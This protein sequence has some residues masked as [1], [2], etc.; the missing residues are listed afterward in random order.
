MKKL[1]RYLPILKVGCSRDDYPLYAQLVHLGKTI[2]TCNDETFISVDN[3][4]LDVKGNTNLFVL[5]SVI[6]S[7]PENYE[8]TQNEQFIEISANKFKTKLALLDID[9]PNFD[10]PSV[11]MVEIDESLLNKISTAYRFTGEDLLSYIY[12]DQF[13]IC[14]TSGH[15]T[16]T[17]S[18][19]LD[20]EEGLF[21]N[22]KILSVLEEGNS[23][24]KDENGNTILDF[25]DGF[26][27]FTVDLTDDYPI[28]KIR[29]FVAT[30]SKGLHELCNVIALQVAVE[31]IS[32]IFFGEKTHLIT[33]VNKNNE[34]RVVAE[35]AMNGKAEA[36]VESELEDKFI[37]TMNVEFLKHVPDRFDVFV[38][39]E[40]GGLF[41]MAGD[42]RIIL[43]GV[44]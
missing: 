26:G 37:L 40:L 11:H 32:H 23:I 27:L 44:Q 25:G 5:D 8:V 42:E 29:S 24:G 16:Y 33:L 36:V 9:F 17:F 3:L 4:G 43:M 10:N 41:L 6:N 15:R 20:L 12:V 18:A 39:R 30:Q 31:R 34:L 22:K 13:G 19:D 38:K 14:G 28:N 21:L 2:R 35:S 1:I 7:L